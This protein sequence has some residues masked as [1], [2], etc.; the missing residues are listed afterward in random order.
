[1]RYP[2]TLETP[3]DLAAIR[4][5]LIELPR[6]EDDPDIYLEY[7]VNGETHNTI[8]TTVDAIPADAIHVELFVPLIWSNK[9]YIF[10]HNR[11]LLKQLF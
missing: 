9:L 7:V 10:P 6:V 5:L 8:F 2:M 4:E 3:D 11:E 1:M